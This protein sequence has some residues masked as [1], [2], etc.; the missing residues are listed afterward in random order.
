M[1]KLT[2]EQVIK[3]A[4]KDY[5]KSYTKGQ[6]GFSESLKLNETLSALI[7]GI[8]DSINENIE[9][10]PSQKGFLR[11]QIRAVRELHKEA[12]EVSDPVGTIQYGEKHKQLI[13]ELF[14]LCEEQ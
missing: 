8:V 11:S 7:S 3:N 14:N 1:K 2:Y 4:L 10:K 12:I 13:S 9:E 5:N 6:L